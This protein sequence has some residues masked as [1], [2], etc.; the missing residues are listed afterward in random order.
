MNKGNRGWYSIAKSEFV[1][2]QLVVTT[3][4][5]TFYGRIITQ[6]VVELLIIEIVA[7]LGNGKSDSNIL[8]FVSFR[9]E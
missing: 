3:T 4:A 5:K 1:S 7:I 6:Q 2:R 9:M 8:I